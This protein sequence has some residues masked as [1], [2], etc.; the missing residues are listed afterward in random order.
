MAFFERFTLN[1]STTGTNPFGSN[2]VFVQDITQQEG[3]SQIE[4]LAQILLELKILN[5]QMYELPRLFATG[6][7]SP[8][9]P[10]MLRN[11]QSIF[12]I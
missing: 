10:E 2:N 1:N 5:Q 3:Q 9:S 4:L 12:N 8:D 7:V 11:E 6:Q